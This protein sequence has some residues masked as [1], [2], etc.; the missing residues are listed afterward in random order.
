MSKYITQ[1]DIPASHLGTPRARAVKK[2]ETE[3]QSETGDE[4]Q[5]EIEPEPQINTQLEGLLVCGIG[6]LFS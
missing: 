3:M 1:F 4:D 6:L 2:V 5:P